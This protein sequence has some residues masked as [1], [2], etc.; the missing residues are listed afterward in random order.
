MGSSEK[1][2]SK[3]SHT[4]DIYEVAFYP[5]GKYVLSASCDLSVKIWDVVTGDCVLTLKE[6]KGVF[7][8]VDGQPMGR[9]WW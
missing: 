3:T 7:F 5:N 9:R 1:E 6:F 4:N 8:T 2:N